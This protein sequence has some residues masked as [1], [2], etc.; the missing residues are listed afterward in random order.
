M[1]LQTLDLNLR[2]IVMLALLVWLF[3]RYTWVMAAL[4]LIGGGIAL[5]IL[6]PLDIYYTLMPLAL[7]G[8]GLGMLL[9]HY[10]QRQLR[11]KREARTPRSY[12]SKQDEF[13]L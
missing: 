7:L 13:H 8:V 2:D 12:T 1:V 9:H 3:V 5:L 11:L 4:T 10:Q 6:L